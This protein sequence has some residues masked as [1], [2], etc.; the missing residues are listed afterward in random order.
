MKSIDLMRVVT[1]MKD[2]EAIKLSREDM[3]EAA[4]AI[5]DSL[6][7]DYVRESDIDDFIDQIENNWDIVVTKNLFGNDYLILNIGAEEPPKRAGL[8]Q[9]HGIRFGTC[10]VI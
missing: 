10:K 2:G 6:L 1:S 7:L 3:L 9:G 4:S 8:W 5:I